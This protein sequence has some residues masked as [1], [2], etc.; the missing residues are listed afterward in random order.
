MMDEGTSH[1]SQAY[2]IVSDRVVVQE[3]ATC[4]QRCRSS[5]GVHLS[6]CKDGV[7]SLFGQVAHTLVRDISFE[8]IRLAPEVSQLPASK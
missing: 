5:G 3:E 4:L 8:G 1:S 7:Q 2:D 6:G